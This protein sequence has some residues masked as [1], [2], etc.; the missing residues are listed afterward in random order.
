MLERAFLVLFAVSAFVALF[1]L[2]DPLA[3]ADALLELFAKAG[4]NTIVGGK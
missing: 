1:G 4:G 2:V 3:F